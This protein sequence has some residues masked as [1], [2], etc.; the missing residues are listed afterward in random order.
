[1]MFNTNELIL[2]AVI[3]S[4]VASTPEGI[5]GFKIVQNVRSKIDVPENTFYPLLKQMQA[6]GYLEVYHKDIGG[7]SRRFYKITDS[8]RE[9]LAYCQQ[10][11]NNYLQ[12]ASSLLNGVP[13]QGSEAPASP[14]VQ[15]VPAQEAPVMQAQPQEMPQA[16]EVPVMQAQPQEMPQ[17]QETPVMQAQPQEMPQAQEAPVMQAQPQESPQAQ[18]ESFHIGGASNTAIDFDFSIG[19]DDS[20]TS[21]DMGFSSDEDL[22]EFDSIPT[23]SFISYEDESEETIEAPAA[24]QPQPIY[25]EAAATTE[26]QPVYQEPAPEPVYEEPAAVQPQPVYEEQVVAEAQQPVYEEQVVA[27]AQQPV[28]EEPMA[29]QAQPVYEEPAPEPVYEEPTQEVVYEEAPAEAPVAVE[30]AEEDVPYEEDD[31]AD[32]LAEMAMGDSEE[33][34]E[35]ASPEE[36]NSMSDLATI[37]ELESMLSQLRSFESVMKQRPEQNAPA[38]VEEAQAMNLNDFNAVTSML[39]T[40]VPMEAPDNVQQEQAPSPASN[41]YMEVRNR[42]TDD[43]VN[44]LVDLLKDDDQ[45]KKRG[46][47]GRSRKKNAP[48]EI[49]PTSAPTP[50][51]SAPVPPVSKSVPPAPAPQAPKPPVQASAPAPAVSPAPARQFREVRNT[52]NDDSV[53]SLVDLLKGDS[54]PKPKLFK[55]RGGKTASDAAPAG[56]AR[57][58]TSQPNA[59]V[60]VT[61]APVQNTHI[62]NPSVSEPK[63]FKPTAAKTFEEKAASP[64]ARP[65]ET[66]ATITKPLEAKAISTKPSE[67]K[68]VEA[69]SVETKAVATPKPEPAAEKKQ[70]APEIDDFKRRLMMAHLIPEGE[71]NK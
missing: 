32:F 42:E 16:Q 63:V 45:P 55:G 10:S 26:P 38:A 15:E 23:S 37:N 48:K 13:A 12:G 44:S 51:R 27:E 61:A 68:P 22:F 47:F 25:A 19:D 39:D 35:E 18:E 3:L 36:E 64:N 56:Y 52:E 59:T 67:A 49:K 5:S 24:A 33:E 21:D 2:D 60:D 11:W 54:E 28:Y 66:T 34:Q 1:M 40:A 46:F 20:I 31:E 70:E 9:H 43:S 69:K 41:R 65:V 62:P 58:S 53:N 4:I 29:A 30:A 14:E 7:R 71:E 8:G 17:A 50:T 57:V 6:D